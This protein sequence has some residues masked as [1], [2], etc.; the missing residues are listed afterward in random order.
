MPSAREEFFKHSRFV[1][2]GNS[3][4]HPF[5][6]FTYR[7]LKEQKKTVY[8]IDAAADSVEGDQTYKEFR[9]IPGAIDAVILELPADETADWVVKTLQAGVKNI[10]IHD[11]TETPD[12]LEKARE[13]GVTLHTGT[14]AVMYVMP[15]TF[16]HNFHRWIMQELGKY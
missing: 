8:A 9:S 1:V 15:R 6:K 5:P 11:G 4:R 7:G 14:C 12:A 3:S 13:A 10:W 16:P 2:V